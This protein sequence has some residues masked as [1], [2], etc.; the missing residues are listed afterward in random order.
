MKN[1]MGGQEELPKV[2]TVLCNDGSSFNH[3]QGDCSCGTP[4]SVCEGHGGFNVCRAF[5]HIIT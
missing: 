4:P 1:V 2:D 5:G 3:P